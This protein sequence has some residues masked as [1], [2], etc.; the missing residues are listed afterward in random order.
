[1]SQST[2]LGPVKQRA[3]LGDVGGSPSLGKLGK[4][5]TVSESLT[6]LMM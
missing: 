6:A 5:W 2:R 4:G 3:E 1:V